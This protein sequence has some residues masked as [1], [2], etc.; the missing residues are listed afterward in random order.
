MFDAATLSSP[1]ADLDRRRPPV[2]PSGRDDELGVELLPGRRAPA[3]FVAALDR[4]A[5]TATSAG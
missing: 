5:E 4:A 2:G 3:Q 1:S